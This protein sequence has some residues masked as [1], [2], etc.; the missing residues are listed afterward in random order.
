[1]SKRRLN[2]TGTISLEDYQIHNK[3]HK[4]K[5]VLGYFLF[6]MITFAI[7]LLATGTVTG[8][9]P[10]VVIIALILGSVIGG[11]STFMLLITNRFVAKREYKSDQL[12]QEEMTLSIGPKGIEQK[13]R[14]SKTL[15]E[16]KHFIKFKEHPQL[17]QLYVSK[18]KALIIP[19]HFFETD[20]EIKQFKHEVEERTQLTAQS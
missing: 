1:M 12:I 18:N 6:V 15:F 13:I 8:S 10:I 3:H 16:W 19:K 11:I 20:E 4:K 17:F 2:I 14:N 5:L 7:V 9:L